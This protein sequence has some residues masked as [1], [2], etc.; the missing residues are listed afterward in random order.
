MHLPP[1]GIAAHGDVQNTEQW[2]LPFD[3]AGR[4]HDQ[5]SAGAKNGMIASEG[6]QGSAQFVF[7]HELAH[8]GAFAPGDD[9]PVKAGEVGR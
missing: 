4:E 1:K 2:L 8:G 7:F 6:P 3:G 5:A 9:E